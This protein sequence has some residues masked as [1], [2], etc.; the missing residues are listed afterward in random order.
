[1][2]AG[3][4]LTI[5]L[6]LIGTAISLVCAAVSAAGWRHPVLISGLFGLA[7]ICFLAGVAWPVLKTISPPATA[8]VTEVAT[9]PVAWFCILI[10]SLALSFLPKREVARV[11]SSQPQAPS[12]QPHPASSQPQAASKQPAHPAPPQAKVLIDVEPSYLIGL[13]ENRTSVQGD[14]LALA[15]IGKWITVTG[16]VQDISR[17][18]GGILVQIIDAKG[19]WVAATFPVESANT[20]TTRPHGSTLTVRGKVWLIDALRV[21][22]AECELIHE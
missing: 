6:F 11:T 15:Y 3:D 22:L 16:R 5:A 19:K 7:G 12:S 14:A 18:A 10:L 21:F 2:L 8:V 1:M 13:Y 20:V 17:N 4:D 9:N